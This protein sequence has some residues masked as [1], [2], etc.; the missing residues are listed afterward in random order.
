MTSVN[1]LLDYLRK[2]DDEKFVPYEQTPEAQVPIQDLMG[3]VSTPQ[4]DIPNKAN[5]PNL[6]NTGAGTSGSM[7]DPSEPAGHDRLYL[8]EI[9]GQAP[10]G[11]R[12]KVFTGRQNAQFIDRRLLTNA[13]KEALHPKNENKSTSYGGIIINSKGQI[14]L[15]KPK[16]E[17]DGYSWTY[18]K[19]QID[20]NETPKEAALREVEEE[21]GLKG[22]IIGQIP[23]HFEST[24]NNKF[25]L[26]QV[27]ESDQMEQ[28]I[29]DFSSDETSHLKWFSPAEAEAA[30]G[31]TKNEQGKKRDLD[32]LKAAF[33]E[34]QHGQ[35]KNS[36]MSKYL[37]QVTAVS[38]SKQLNDPTSEELSHFVEHG[39]LPDYYINPDNPKFGE[40]QHFRQSVKDRLIEP[41]NVQNF[42]AHFI[43]K[44]YNSDEMKELFGATDGVSS[45][46]LFRKRLKA[47]W[48]G[49]PSSSEEGHAATEYI[50][51]LLG[52]PQ[53]FFSGSG[54]V[55]PLDIDMNGNKTHWSREQR[56]KLANEWQKWKD[57]TSKNSGKFDLP[58]AYDPATGGLKPIVKVDL[59]VG[60]WEL[61]AERAFHTKDARKGLDA[62]VSKILKA[63]GQNIPKLE[64]EAALKTENARNRAA[65]ERM[66]RD[67]V[68]RS[69]RISEQ[70]L[71]MAFPNTDSMV[72]W[73]G[74][75]T[76]GEI[77]AG[78]DITGREFQG[79]GDWEAKQ[80]LTEA[81]MPK[82]G[83]ETTDTVYEGYINSRPTSGWGTHPIA[84]GGKYH[85]A[86]EIPKGDVFMT[87]LDFQGGHDGASLGGYENR[88]KEWLIMNNPNLRAKIFHHASN[89]NSLLTTSED[90]HYLRDGNGIA[91]E[92]I[93]HDKK[94]LGT[95]VED[96]QSGKKLRWTIGVDEPDNDWSEH[97]DIGPKAGTQ[98][99]GMYTDKDGQQWY[100][101]H[102]AESQHVVE[103]LA[104]KIYRHAGINVPET[105]L[106][107][108]KGKV[109]HASKM[110]T[111]DGGG[112]VPSSISSSHE[113]IHDGFFVDA[114]LAN[115]DV[116]GTGDSNLI[117]DSEGKIHRIDNGGSLYLKATSGAS[118]EEKSFGSADDHKTP[119]SELETYIDPK[120]DNGSTRSSMFKDMPKESKQ[121]AFEKLATLNNTSIADI[122]HASGIPPY[123]MDEI[124]KALISR[125]NNII[126]TLV[127]SKEIET[128]TGGQSFRDIEQEYKLRKE[129]LDSILEDNPVVERVVELLKKRPL[130]QLPELSLRDAEEKNDP[131]R[132]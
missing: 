29:A 116:A 11:Y 75:S 58:P 54:K 5:I 101:K 27:G 73:R 132:S 110:L 121:R 92:G 51:E 65:G 35:N 17:A 67:F 48:V 102:G 14:L 57:G 69:R 105:K 50:A 122:V 33:H 24:S 78:T 3:N 118:G 103:D 127:D 59:S 15:R 26:M 40:Y 44:L 8:S 52:S 129:E 81:G 39:E 77:R 66:V 85:I 94:G 37:S 126:Q 38:T 107:N 93:F 4:V 60:G 82:I 41:Q 72:L 10:K 61:A 99:G 71:D 88:E 128:T 123:R 112:E 19:G 36:K 7:K 53:T 100:I 63:Y 1:D 62:S 6:P 64:S 95:Y 49:S 16:G 91:P 119:L 83:E 20:G 84:F 21:T 86:A 111:T 98:S 74:T 79:G 109:A 22:S 117:M 34:H 96:P 130:L 45:M 113:D 104:N 115:W 47:N 18:A 2:E 25:Y 87:S 56:A 68:K 28:S 30:I 125:R 55:I 46:S 70:F 13:Q 106:I 90:W 97:G 23:G 89:S 9:G 124:T 108:W 114:L 31:E 80:A 120:Y 32:I 42:F 76:A 131:E 12:G 43:G